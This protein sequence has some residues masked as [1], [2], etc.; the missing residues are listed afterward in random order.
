MGTKPWLRLS[1][2]TDWLLLKVRFRSTSA[3]AR[4]S[5]Q[6]L[7]SRCRY[8]F[9]MSLIAVNSFIDQRGPG[10]R[11]SR[12]RPRYR[13]PLCDHRNRCMPASSP[14][15]RIRSGQTSSADRCARLGR[16]CRIRCRILRKQP[17]LISLKK[18]VRDAVRCFSKLGRHRAAVEIDLCSRL[19]GRGRPFQC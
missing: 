1:S 2:G 15:S 13:G 17:P 3:P 14:G 11:T 5:E 8:D 10:Y 7:L 9:R 4:L 18:P 19:A 6:S 16:A 12:R